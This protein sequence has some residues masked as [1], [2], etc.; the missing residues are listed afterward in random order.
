MPVVN[1]E[2]PD[3]PDPRVRMAAERTL[4]AWI[5]TGVA[6]M[7]F[8]FVVAR[9]GWFLREFSA[10]ENQPIPSTRWSLI[11]GVGLVALGVFVNI[12]SAVEHRRFLFRHDK[13][14]P[15]QPPSWSSGIAICMILAVLGAIMVVYLLLLEI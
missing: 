8:G 10:R 2:K 11:L 7:G 4:L 6:M 1:E 13:G 15:Y 12:L 14:L 9:F 5:R 3:T